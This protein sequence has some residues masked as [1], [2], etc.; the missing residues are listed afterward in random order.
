M[1]SNNTIEMAQHMMPRRKT[2]PGLFKRRRG[3]DG[4]IQPR[5]LDF[6]Q[7]SIFDESD[8]AELAEALNLTETLDEAAPPPPRANPLKGK[9]APQP[10]VAKKVHRFELTAWRKAKITFTEGDGFCRLAHAKESDGTG[11]AKSFNISL[12]QLRNMLDSFDRITEAMTAIKEQ[13]SQKTDLFIHLGDKVHVRLHTPYV[14]MNIRVME[15]GP[16]GLYPTKAGIALRAQE[17]LNLEAHIPSLD[18]LL[19]E[20]GVVACFHGNQEAE[21]SCPHCSPYPEVVDLVDSDD[22]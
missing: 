17:L 8:D 16:S 9:P 10:T 13:P 5:R 15:R 22:Y 7:V 4:G 2:R 1:A 18:A 12:L 3:N 14:C 6:S 19:N 21:T 20:E 11:T